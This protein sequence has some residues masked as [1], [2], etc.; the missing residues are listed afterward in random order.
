MLQNL[1]YY[2]P[3]CALRHLC[4][5]DGRAN[6]RGSSQR[7]QYS[8]EEKAHVLDFIEEAQ[9]KGLPLKSVCTNPEALENC[10]VL[11]RKSLSTAACSQAGQKDTAAAKIRKCARNLQHTGVYCASMMRSGAV[12]S[13]RVHLF[14]DHFRNV[15]RIRS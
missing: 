13:G 4:A 11:G 8:W 14:R 7:H 9:S 2:P 15:L 5:V 10:P 1:I 12:W 6:N 3:H